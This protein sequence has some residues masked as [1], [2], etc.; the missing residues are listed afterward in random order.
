MRRFQTYHQSNDTTVV[1]TLAHRRSHN[2]SQ[3]NGTLAPLTDRSRP[4]RRPVALAV[5]RVTLTQI[6]P[7]TDLARATPRGAAGADPGHAGE[8]AGVDS[9]G[10]RV[11]DLV[12]PSAS[13]PSTP[14]HSTTTRRSNYCTI[15]MTHTFMC[16]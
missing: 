12:M 11:P 4:R 15:S 7:A 3:I 5:D 6:Q 13:R 8:G 1:A 10:E 2:T 16:V 9:G 14:R